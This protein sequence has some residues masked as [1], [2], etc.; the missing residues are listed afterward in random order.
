[1]GRKGSWFSAV[2][3]VFGSENKKDQEKNT[4]PQK[5]HSHGHSHSNS[6][7][8]LGCFGHHDNN[9]AG[10]EA[11]GIVVVP[12]LP[13]KKEPKQAR[14]AGQ[15]EPDQ[16]A[17]S[18][19]LATAV[20]AGAAVAAAAEATRPKTVTPRRR[21]K[22]K[23][24]EAA[25]MIQTAFRGYLARKKLRGLR[26]LSRLRTLVR[27]QSVKRQSASTLQCMQTLSKLQSQVR[28]RKIRMSEENQAL[29]RQLLQKR[30]KELEKLQAAQAEWD[31][32]KDSKEQVEAKLL[33]RQIATMRREKA[34]AYS[35]THQQTW[36]NNLKSGTNASF[37]DPNNPHWGWNWL[38]RWMA[39]R[40]WEGQST[41]QHNEP[42]P[43]ISTAR[44]TLSV[45][46]ITKL[47]TLRDDANISKNSPRAIK[48]G[49]SRSGLNSPS[50]VLT[51]S[52]STAFFTASPTPRSLRAASPKLGSWGGDGDKRNAFGIRREGNRRHSIAISPARDDE[53]LNSPMNRSPKKAAAT[54]ASKSFNMAKSSVSSS[55]KSS[56]AA[57][58]NKR[59]SLSQSPTSNSRRLSTPGKVGTISNKSN[60]A[61][62]SPDSQFLATIFHE[63]KLSSA[64]LIS[65][66]SPPVSGLSSSRQLK[67]SLPCARFAGGRRRQNRHLAPRV[68]VVVVFLLLAVSVSHLVVIV[69]LCR[70]RLGAPSPLSLP[71]RDW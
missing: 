58:V 56:P 47:Y 60:A 51:P 34:L 6:K 14:V 24:D 11:Q 38:E 66:P 69:A 35:M 28:A 7:S 1:M 45:G 27:G 70:H 23:D 8:K 2:K 21:E 71:P 22:L 48:T 63:L 31:H 59:L 55:E 13:R 26:G 50:N 20:A 61:V 40:P 3:K 29:Q 17:F 18:L 36:R 15:N 68:V 16:Q 53:L 52:K 4:K 44:S 65:G 19:V 37:M 62:S 30:E 5:T 49:R 32:R 41:F 46:E 57:A 42:A 33:H 9:E 10:N 43:L 67:H 25:I 54:K 64:S 39:V 12:A